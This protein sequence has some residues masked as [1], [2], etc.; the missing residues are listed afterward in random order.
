MFAVIAVIIPIAWPRDDTMMV[1][2]MKVLF[3]QGGVRDEFSDGFQRRVGNRSRVGLALCDSGIGPGH[4]F[5]PKLYP[6]L[7]LFETWAGEM[8]KCASWGRH[9]HTYREPRTREPTG[10]FLP[11]CRNPFLEHFLHS[12]SSLASSHDPAAP[13]NSRAIPF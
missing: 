1:E 11:M 12:F 5:P 8:P 4:S 6:L 7:L 2:K 10:P 9:R 3:K 13:P